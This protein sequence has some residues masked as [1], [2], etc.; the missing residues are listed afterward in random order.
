M[1]FVSDSL[2]FGGIPERKE[3]ENPG[4]WY[5]INVSSI[6]VEGC[7]SD[8]NI[9]LND[10]AYDGG[11]TQEEFERAVEEVRKALKSEEK[12]FVHCAIGQSRSVS[13]LATAIA[14]EQDAEF[15]QVKQELMDI[16]GTFTEPAE[17]LKVKAKRYLRTKDD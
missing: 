13:V 12:L 10:G 16:R 3:I 2:A 11:N 14:A 17:S 8:I 5:I 1:Y 9:Q 15:P 4:D 7:E 6:N